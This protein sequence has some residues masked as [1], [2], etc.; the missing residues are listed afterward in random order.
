MVTWKKK[1]TGDRPI[2]FIFTFN[3]IYLCSFFDEQNNIAKFI[4][5]FFFNLISTAINVLFISYCNTMVTLV[6][7]QLVIHFKLI[8]V[9]QLPK[10]AEINIVFK[11]SRK[12]LSASLFFFMTLSFIYVFK[13]AFKN[14]RFIYEVN[15]TRLIYA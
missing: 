9:E 6:F 2:L 1:G 13:S 11:A 3:L 15:I 14:V 10:S 7:V 5:A 4:R 12:C 8:N